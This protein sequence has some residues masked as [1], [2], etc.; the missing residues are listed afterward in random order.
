M[1]VSS[2][3][4]LSPGLRSLILNAA[5]FL[6]SHK[7]PFHQNNSEMNIECIQFNEN[8]PEIDMSSNSFGSFQCIGNCQNNIK[9]KMHLSAFIFRLS[10]LPSNFNNCLQKYQKSPFYKIH[11]KIDFCERCELNLPRNLQ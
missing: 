3:A 8:W 1:M 9:L 2:V 11:C 7:A 6:E 4:V 5:T 10:R